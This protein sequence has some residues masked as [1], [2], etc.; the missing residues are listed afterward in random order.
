MS[1][2]YFIWYNLIPV[3]KC[4]DWVIGDCY[5]VIKTSSLLSKYPYYHLLNAGYGDGSVPGVSLHPGHRKSGRAP[6]HAPRWDQTQN[7]QV[8]GLSEIGAF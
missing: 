6:G 5:W 1:G 3:G 8:E 2:K 4:M 7:Q